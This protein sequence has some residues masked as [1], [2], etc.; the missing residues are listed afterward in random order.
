MSLLPENALT[1]P[2]IIGRHWAPWWL[3]LVLSLLFLSEAAVVSSHWFIFFAESEGCLISLLLHIC[4]VFVFDFSFS[5]LTALTIVQQ[6]HPSTVA[7]G[8][9]TPCCSLRQT[10]ELVSLVLSSPAFRLL[11]GSRS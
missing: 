9:S 3:V 10:V 2:A 6:A 11:V 4:S 7:L 8:P 5:L 1:H